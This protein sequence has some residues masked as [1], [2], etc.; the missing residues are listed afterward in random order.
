MEGG[1][2][3]HR[4]WSLRTVS[5]DWRPIYTRQASTTPPQLTIAGR[6][7]RRHRRCS[8]IRPLPGLPHD[9]WVA[10]GR[11]G[12]ATRKVKTVEEMK[13]VVWI[14]LCGERR[15]WMSTGWGSCSPWCLGS[16][17]VNLLSGEIATTPPRADHCRMQARPVL[18]LRPKT[19]A[20]ATLAGSAGKYICHSLENLRRGDHHRIPWA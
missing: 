2:R 15:A 8:P 17:R 18:P 5:Q 19:V 13:S 1:I 14:T 3:D 9:P 10:A 20:W 7:R 12:P 16:L 6:S 4:N 11:T